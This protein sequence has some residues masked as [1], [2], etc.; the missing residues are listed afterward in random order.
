M[1]SASDDDQGIY[2]TLGGRVVCKQCTARSKRSGQLCKAPAVSG[3][4]V[5]RM[6]GARGGVKTEEG[7][8]R[9]AA[10]NTIHGRETRQIRAERSKI[11]KQLRQL[12]DIGHWL[13][14]LIGSRTRGPKAKS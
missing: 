10:A 12:E 9:T 1:T 13:G 6:H 5:C 4:N 11:L 2:K 3:F 7:R 14:F 8:A